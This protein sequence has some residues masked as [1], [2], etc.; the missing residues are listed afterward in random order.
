LSTAN[1]QR[2]ETLTGGPFHHVDHRRAVL[3]TRCDIEEHEFIRALAIIF[4]RA[5][6][7]VT[8]VAQV[9]ELRSLHHASAIHVQTGY[10]AFRQHEA[11]TIPQ[12]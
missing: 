12:Q 1:R 10:D 6:D 8:R 3:G 2:H 5:L 7:R 9:Q 4:L 11:G